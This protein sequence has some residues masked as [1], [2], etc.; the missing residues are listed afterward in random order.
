MDAYVEAWKEAGRGHTG[1]AVK[2]LKAIVEKDPHFYRASLL[3][4]E[5][6]V[7]AK[8]AD[9][10]TDYLLQRSRTAPTA[11]V[12]AGLGQVFMLQSDFLKAERYLSRCIQ[13]VPAVPW[14]YYRLGEAV[15]KAHKGRL[16][17]AN[18]LPATR[19][20][21]SN[22]C[23]GVLAYF[24]ERQQVPKVL[25]TGREC[26]DQIEQRDDPEAALQLHW[27]LRGIYSLSGTDWEL[28]LDHTE[29]ARRLAEA[30]GDYPL[31]LHLQCAQATILVQLHD[32]NGARRVLQECEA[33]AR[34]LEHQSLLRSI[35]WQRAGVE[36]SL[37]EPETA[38]RLYLQIRT[39][40]L[41]ANNAFEAAV[42]SRY[43]G[44]ALMDAGRIPDAKELLHES[45]RELG[46]FNSL[47]AR[48]DRA[49]ALQYLAEVHSELGEFSDAIRCAQAAVRLHRGL[50]MEWQAGMAYG[51]IAA[52]YRAIG[53]YEAAAR[54]IRLSLKSAQ[55]RFDRAEEQKALGQ[56]GDVYVRMGRLEEAVQTLRR[57][58]LLN[59]Y[60][61]APRAHASALISLGYGYERLGQHERAANHFQRAL[62]VSSERGPAHMEAEA[63]YQLGATL[64]SKGQLEAATAHLKSAWNSWASRGAAVLVSRARAQLARIER[65][66]GNLKGAADHI[67]AAVSEVESHRGG[68][69]T[70]ELRLA[71]LGDHSA[72]FDEALRIYSELAA[73]RPQEGFAWK[74]LTYAERGRAWA[75]HDQIEEPRWKFIKRLNESQ[76]AELTA[77]EISWSQAVTRAEKH[78]SKDTMEAADQKEQT[79]REYWVNLRLAVN[80]QT[81]ASREAHPL[82]AIVARVSRKS[83][84][85]V[86]EYA[87][88]EEQSYLWIVDSQGVRMIQLPPRR[89]IA[90]L[91]EAYR[92]QIAEHLPGNR[93]GEN[94]RGCRAEAVALYRLLLRPAERW[95]HNIES[96]LI[97][98]DGPLNYLPFEALCRG[99]GEPFLVENYTVRYAASLTV[100]DAIDRRGPSRATRDLLIFA[101]P[102]YN[103]IGRSES[104]AG[105]TRSVDERGGFSFAGLPNTRREAASVTS[106]Y[107]PAQREVRLGKHASES[108]IKSM[109]LAN[110]RLLHFAAHGLLNEQAPGRSGVVLSLTEPENGE[111]GILRME[112]IASLRLDA[113]LVLLSACQTGLGALR[114]G[115]GLVGLSSAFLH[116]GARRVLVTLWA[117]N[118]V[119]APEFVVI[120]Y[121]ALLA[122][123]PAAEALRS[124]KLSMIHSKVA[125]YRHPYFWA[126]FVLRGAE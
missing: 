98:P 21:D 23:L 26:Q 24:R 62:T 51:D 12:Y 74:A 116:A 10:A 68:V 84:T 27:Q 86:F 77:H 14:C 75:L 19:A 121:K 119:A 43:A 57:A 46:Q 45:L 115:E 49:W 112:E 82:Q 78:P 18:F 5:V 102:E 85:T 16:R 99:V 20:S 81:S 91:V 11:G 101:D 123:K 83:G 61:N 125:A 32:S 70:P 50:G 59:R 34:R 13:S 4:A 56:L 111:D 87:V 95:M 76:R 38:A 96:L 126:P 35:L 92:A 60:T 41:T 73:V 44:R 9:M 106:L 55:T 47:P 53:D 120:F 29:R 100:L 30:L 15:F 90:A 52:A 103:S 54:Y 109:N 118:D 58:V 1:A 110:F 42:S 8:Q 114:R 36:Q 107:A 2:S 67:D 89:R 25:A 72:I 104:R 48:S 33:T 97:V 69:P 79:L 113:D 39:M 37:G 6:S 3:L 94:V 88:G 64:V 17:L 65:L 105:L 63:H 71:Y 124:A 117:L 66:R 108:S 28:A 93:L 7:G 40:A 122:G 31:N 22:R 80:G